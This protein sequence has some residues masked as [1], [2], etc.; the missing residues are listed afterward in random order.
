MGQYICD[1]YLH[2]YKKNHNIDNI[3][4]IFKLVKKIILKKILILQL[5]RFTSQMLMLKLYHKLLLY[6]FMKILRK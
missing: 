6:I 4:K 2:I 5:L 3:N 1:I